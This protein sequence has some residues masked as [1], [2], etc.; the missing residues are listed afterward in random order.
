MKFSAT[1]YHIFGGLIVALAILR[2]RSRD[3]TADQLDIG[4]PFFWMVSYTD[5]SHWRSPG[6]RPAGDPADRHPDAGL[7]HVL[8]NIRPA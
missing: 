8:G 3:I 4:S 1:P 5:R 7:P 6:C 2:W